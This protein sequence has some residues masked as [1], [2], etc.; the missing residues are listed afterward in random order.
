MTKEDLIN[1]IS[2]IL[3]PVGFK[4]KGK[5]WVINH[6]ELTKIVNLQQSNFGNSFYI[7]FGFIIKKLK[8]NEGIDVYHRLRQ[9]K[10]STSN[11]VT[12]LLNLDF[13]ISDAARSEELSILID[14]QIVNFFNKI[15][16]EDDLKMELE[17][18]EFRNDILLAVKHYFKL[19]D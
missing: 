5:N 17:S 1:L 16:C 19:A 2:N 9:S 7:N 13:E 4:R 18:R 3:I 11:S 6:Q 15:N 14:T 10:S 12:D 8:L